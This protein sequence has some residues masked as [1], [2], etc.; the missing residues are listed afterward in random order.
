MLAERFHIGEWYGHPFLDLTDEERE[1]LSRHKVGGSALK[2]AEVE[3]LTALER[4]DAEGTLTS[5]EIDRLADLRNKLDEQNR[6]EKPCP[7]RTDTA[8]P[9]CTKS[10]GVC[11]LQLLSDDSGEVRGVTGERGMVRALCPYRFHQ[12]NA[13]FKHVGQRLLDDAAPHQIG[14]VG[15]LESTGNLDS[16]PGADVG[17]IDMILVSHPQVEQTPLKWAAVEIQAVYFSGREMDIEFRHMRD[18]GGVL[19][20]PKASRRPDYR[21][22]GPKRLMPQLQ[23]KVPT[24][25]R[26]GKKMAV[27]VDL[28]FFRSMGEMRPVSHVSNADIVWFLVD[29]PETA[30][31]SLRSL[32]VV[33]EIYTTLESAIEGLTGG[34]PVSLD[35]FE[36]RIRT[37]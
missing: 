27:I 10:G 31:G 7:F 16:A 15:F 26:W 17:Y 24:L 37:K 1:S 9:T 32:T 3:R 35:E 19:S 18:T 14:E 34:V 28:P 23:I 12:D 8:Y 21:S 2:K 29:F 22:S 13:I 11:S 20:M 33:D 6:N 25:R 30:K 4:K 36:E 5:R